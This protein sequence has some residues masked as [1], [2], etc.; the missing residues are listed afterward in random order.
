MPRLRI[1]LDQETY[2]TLLARADQER[3]PM[4]L[5]AEVMLRIALGLKFPVPDVID[6]T[7]TEQAQGELVGVR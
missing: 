2:M 6:V 3:R 1:A 4:D 5:Q 7:P